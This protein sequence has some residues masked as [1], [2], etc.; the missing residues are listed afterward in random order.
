MTKQ[1]QPR[2]L[3][4]IKVVT[5]DTDHF[6][7][8]CPHCGTYLKVKDSWEKNRVIYFLLECLT[9]KGTGVRKIPLD[10]FSQPIGQKA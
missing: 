9:C 5:D 2:E 4:N 7:F 3:E 8:E 6:Y 1:S 10:S